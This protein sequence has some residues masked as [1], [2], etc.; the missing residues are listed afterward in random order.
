[1]IFLTF[2]WSVGFRLADCH[3]RHLDLVHSWRLEAGREEQE[4][5]LLVIALVWGGF[6]P[7]LQ[8]LILLPCS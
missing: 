5:D 3:M 4:G 7:L 8:Q 2:T 1:M 6:K